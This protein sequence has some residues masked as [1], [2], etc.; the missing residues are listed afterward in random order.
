VVEVGSVQE[1]CEVGRRVLCRVHASMIGDDMRRR[2]E[3]AAYEDMFV[4]LRQ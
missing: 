3:I 4:R 2:K 1:D